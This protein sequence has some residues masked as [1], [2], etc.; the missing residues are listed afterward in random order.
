MSSQLRGTFSTTGRNVSI[1]PVQGRPIESRNCLTTIVNVK[2][3]S[4]NDIAIQ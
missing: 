4:S 1:A 2:G 3:T